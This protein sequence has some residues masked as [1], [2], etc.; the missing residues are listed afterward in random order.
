MQAKSIDGMSEP[1]PSYR[2]HVEKKAH[3]AIGILQII[4][5]AVLIVVHTANTVFSIQGTDLY[6]PRLLMN[7]H[8]LHDQVIW[9]GALF[10]VTGSFGVATSRFPKKCMMITY[11]VLCLVSLAAAT[12][13]LL[14]LGVFELLNTNDVMNAKTTTTTSYYNYKKESKNVPDR[15]FFAVEFIICI[16]LAVFESVLSLVGSIFC[17]NVIGCCSTPSYTQEDRIYHY[18]GLKTD[19]QEMKP[20]R[21]TA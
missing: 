10:I 21:Q 20:L 17:C 8:L 18:E 13:L 3:M 16:I 15:N 11:M 1:T 19:Q 4:F 12:I 7:T 9:M 2:L 14:F 6:V 5:G